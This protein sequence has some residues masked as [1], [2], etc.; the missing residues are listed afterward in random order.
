MNQC[1]VPECVGFVQC[2]MAEGDGKCARFI[3]CNSIVVCIR[4][5]RKSTGNSVIAGDCR[6]SFHRIVGFCF[7]HSIHRNRRRRNQSHTQC[8]ANYSRDPCFPEFH[9]KTLLF[10]FVKDIFTIALYH[11]IHS[12]SIIHPKREK[13][14]C[15]LCR[16]Y[17]GRIRIWK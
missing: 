6:C 14:R 15:F 12:L 16:I 1:A 7:C 17:D 3:N 9:D 4:V 5:F 13:S 8:A 2:F 11:K 10:M